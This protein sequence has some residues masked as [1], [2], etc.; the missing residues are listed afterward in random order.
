MKR[1]INISK[2]V[3]SEFQK[4]DVPLLAAAQ[5]YYY[6]LSIV[7]LLILLLS[8]LPYLNIEAESAVTFISNTLPDGT[9][10]V[11]QDNIISLVTTPKGGLLTIGII[12]TLWSASSGMT[13]FI[14]STNQAYNVEES[15]SFIQVKLLSIILTLGLIVA[16]A[17]ALVLPVFGDVIFQFI[18]RF[19]SIPMEIRVLLEIARWFISLVVLGGVLLLLYRFAPNTKL[20]FKRIVPGAAITTVLWLMISFAFSFYVSNFGS[21]SATYGSLGGVVILMIW[22]FLTGL[23]LML[24]AEINVVYQ[25]YKTSSM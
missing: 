20:P 19:V 17:V 3:V 25:R 22:F 6:L 12:G 7:P 14:K 9:A 21:Y 10:S 8:I 16:F 1:F 11:F 2:E 15:R 23:I 18:E 24:G 5:A 13:A 4:D